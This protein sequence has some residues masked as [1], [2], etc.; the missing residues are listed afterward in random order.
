VTSILNSGLEEQNWAVMALI[1]VLVVVVQVSPVLA[2]CDNY[3]NYS[4]V[5]GDIPT[6]GVPGSMAFQGQYAFVVDFD[7]NFT[8]VDISD[9]SFPEIVSITDVAV[10]AKSVS[11]Y[12][13][14]AAI[15]GEAGRKIQLYDISDVT[16]PILL[17]YFPNYTYW[18][19]DEV[20]LVGPYAYLINY[21]DEQFKVFDVSSPTNIVEVASLDLPHEIYS[22]PN[23]PWGHWLFHKLRISGNWAYII[24]GRNG[25]MVVDIS[26]PEAPIEGPTYHF[27]VGENNHFYYDLLVSGNR[28]YI[29]FGHSPDLY[30]GVFDVSD[31]K[32]AYEIGLGQIEPQHHDVFSCQ[33]ALSGS[34]CY[35]SYTNDDYGWV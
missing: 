35:Y 6:S 25:L 27:N 13:S 20:T 19:A 2:Q 12:G 30:L 3:L 1:A 15:V 11:V 34:T 31:P 29:S 18:Q 8:I 33:I 17:G 26:D 10:V 23:S 4:Y 28:L 21:T 24:N 9:I 5:A 16:S 32:N 22:D 7:H 14:I